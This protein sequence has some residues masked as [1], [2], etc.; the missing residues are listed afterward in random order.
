MPSRIARDRA[1]LRRRHYIRQA[2]AFNHWFDFT[3]SRVAQFTARYG[4]NFCLVINGS[5]SID[6]TYI[7]P[8]SR[9]KTTFSPDALD[10]R[11]R[12]IGTVIDNILQLTPSGNSMNVSGFHNAFEL[13]A[14]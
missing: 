3:A 10:Y 12:W 7:I 11:G 1:E 2:T 4:D 14:T 6:D 8:F 13:L 5:N 9:A